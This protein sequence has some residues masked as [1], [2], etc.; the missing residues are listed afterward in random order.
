MLSGWQCCSAVVEEGG[1]HGDDPVCQKVS[2]PRGHPP[3]DLQR[4]QKM[5]VLLF[6]AMLLIL[7]LAVLI[8]LCHQQHQGQ[9]RW[10]V[11][12][13]DKIAPLTLTAL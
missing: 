12:Y 9:E 10:S 2:Q 4:P 5:F 1:C 7:Y 11:G 13:P 8:K 3:H 6:L